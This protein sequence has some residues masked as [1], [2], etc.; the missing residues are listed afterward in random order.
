MDKKNF[1]TVVVM[2]CLNFCHSSTVTAALEKTVEESI[3]PPL[4]RRANAFWTSVNHGGTQTFSLEDTRRPGIW[5]K[6]IAM[7]GSIPRYTRNVEIDSSPLRSME[8]SEKDTINAID[9]TA[10]ATK[11]SKKKKK[12]VEES[13]HRSRYQNLVLENAAQAYHDHPNDIDGYRNALRES[14]KDFPI[15]PDHRHEYEAILLDEEARYFHFILSE[16]ADRGKGM[17]TILIILKNSIWWVA[18]S[19]LIILFLYVFIR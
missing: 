8:E 7:V 19:L 9:A 6:G 3:M 10:H 15:P 17:K 13:I 1:I 18:C 12:D 14:L 5:K 4:H 11:K 16:K 2:G